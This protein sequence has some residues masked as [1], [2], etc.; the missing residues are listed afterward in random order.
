[1][2]T[3]ARGV[4]KLE[5]EGRG[6][7]V[8]RKYAVNPE[9]LRTDRRAQILPLRRFGVRRRLFRVRADMAKAAGHPY[10]IRAHEIFRQVIFGILVEALGIPLFCS[11]VV[12]IRV[13]EEA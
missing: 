11:G 5:K 7:G 6:I 2:R 3:W 4:Q 9:I 1:E 12:E 10:A 8:P 13:G